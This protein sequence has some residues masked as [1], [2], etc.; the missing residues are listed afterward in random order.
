M[1]LKFRWD[2]TAVWKNVWNKMQTIMPW[3]GGGK[4]PQL[5]VGRISVKDGETQER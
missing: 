5:T 4:G 3:G 2:G 1:M